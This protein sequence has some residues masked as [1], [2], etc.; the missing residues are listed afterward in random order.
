MNFSGKGQSAASSSLR[1]PAESSISAVP[2]SIV[3]QL[4][5]K[6][7]LPEGEEGD[8]LDLTGGFIRTVCSGACDFTSG[9]CPCGASKQ[10]IIKLSEI[11]Y[12]K[13]ARAIA[14]LS[15]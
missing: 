7:E 1:H 15:L 4:Q 14:S 5:A 13:N 6:D 11:G 9:T 8:Q 10:M 12:S 2:I 3:F